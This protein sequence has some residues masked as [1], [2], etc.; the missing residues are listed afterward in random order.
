V[1]RRPSPRRAALPV[2][3][4]FARVEEYRS[5]QDGVNGRGDA[6]GDLDRHWNHD[7]AVDDVRRTWQRWITARPDGQPAPEEVRDLNYLAHAASYAGLPDLAAPLFRILGV[8]A[9]RM[10]WSC[11]GDPEAEFVKWRRRSSHG[12]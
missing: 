5:L 12:A 8:R 3:V 7:G 6:P 9:S 2:L 10:P 1:T 11:T 4:Q